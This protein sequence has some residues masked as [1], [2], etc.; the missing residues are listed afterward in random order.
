[1][2]RKSRFRVSISGDIVIEGCTFNRKHYASFDEADEALVRHED[3]TGHQDCAELVN[4]GFIV[5][6]NGCRFRKSRGVKTREDAQRI[7]DE[8]A[9]S[10]SHI[11]RRNQYLTTSR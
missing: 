2:S 4:V 8:H 7:A 5:W 1:M 10:A 6:C 3:K 11:S 9:S